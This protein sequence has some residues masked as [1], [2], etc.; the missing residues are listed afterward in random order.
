MQTLEQSK[1]QAGS[2]A[3]AQAEQCTRMARAHI[4]KG[5]GQS[6][7]ECR[8]Y[9]VTNSNNI[10]TTVP[11]CCAIAETGR[12]GLVAVSLTLRCRCAMAR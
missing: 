5:V 8:R 7:A 3:P 2:G 10:G 9:V 12:T 11:K 4:I 6:Q 1:L